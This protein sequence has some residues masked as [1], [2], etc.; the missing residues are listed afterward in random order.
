MKE[1]FLI[2]GGGELRER[3]NNFQL[4]DTH[5]NQRI[6]TKKV[7]WSYSLSTSFQRLGF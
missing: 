1:E 3:K 6:E 4:F 5:L 2:G 7:A